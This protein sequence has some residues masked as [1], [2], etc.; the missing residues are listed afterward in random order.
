[1]NQRNKL[2][3]KHR[4]K[5][6]DIL[7]K[8]IDNQDKFFKNF[9]GFIF[10]G[11][12]SIG[13]VYVHKERLIQERVTLEKKLLSL[14]NEDSM[15]EIEIKLSYL[16]SINSISDEEYEMYLLALKDGTIT[17][18]KIHILLSHYEVPDLNVKS[19]L[20]IENNNIE[21]VRFSSLLLH[22][23]INQK[24][25]LP[26]DI[27][28]FDNI[29]KKEFH[30]EKKE[31]L[32]E[33]YDLREKLNATNIENLIDSFSGY[34]TTKKEKKL[35]EILDTLS[36]EATIDEYRCRDIRLIFHK[37]NRNL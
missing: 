37:I 3:I 21:F 6:I 19:T 2:E 4:L 7:L 30:I 33:M 32:S 20:A 24:N 25:I 12:R 15:K 17:K 8:N 1:M 23:C 22:Y 16:K 10:D 36:L 34:F 13:E 29:L 31:I 14:K 27:Y 28:F 11:G 35:F 26:K 9:I 5:Q 18:E